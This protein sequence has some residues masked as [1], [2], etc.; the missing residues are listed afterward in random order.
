MD[1]EIEF[2]DQV[3]SP[4]VC[5]NPSGICDGECSRCDHCNGSSEPFPSVF[6]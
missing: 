3:L 4:D 5:E 2:S 1:T 6:E